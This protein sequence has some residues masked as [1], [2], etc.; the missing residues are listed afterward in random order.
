MKGGEGGGGRNYQ[1]HARNSFNSKVSFLIFQLC[2]QCGDRTS[3]ILSWEQL[4]SCDTGRERARRGRRWGKPAGKH[5][6]FLYTFR[7]AGTVPPFLPSP[8]LR[9]GS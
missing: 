3:T 2:I 4:N 6:K 9:R 1:D 7:F 8:T 5:H